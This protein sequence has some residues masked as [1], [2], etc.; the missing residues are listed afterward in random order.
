MDAAQAVQD[1]APL[2]RL[3]VHLSIAEDVNPEP[4]PCG[5]ACDRRPDG[6]ERAGDPPMPSGVWPGENCKTFDQWQRH[7]HPSRC[8]LDMS[9]NVLTFVLS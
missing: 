7:K 4:G 2:R 9:S 1:G 3:V 8:D 5:T 6:R